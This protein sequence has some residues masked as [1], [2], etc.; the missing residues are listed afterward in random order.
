MGFTAEV[1][2]KFLALGCRETWRDLWHWIDITIVLFWL[3]GNLHELKLPLNPLLL[4]LVRLVRLLRLLKLIR[5]MQAMDAL[6]VILTSIKCSISILVWAIVV[7]TIG[8]M[9]FGLIAQQLLMPYMEDEAEL[10]EKRLNV[11]LHFGTFTRCW[12]T[13]LELTFGGWARIGRMLMEDVSGW[14]ALPILAHQ[15]MIGF[16]VLTVVRGVFM[17][18]TFKV[19]ETD[20]FIMMKTRKREANVHK[21]KMRRLFETADTDHDGFLDFDEFKTIMSNNWVKEWLFAYGLMV[22][23]VGKMWTLIDRNRD[24]KI[25][26]DE[27]VSGMR[28]LRG[29]ARSIDM[30]GLIHDIKGLGGDANSQVEVDSPATPFQNI[31]IFGPPE[32]E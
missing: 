16:A 20:N 21:T 27:L 13:M 11:F 18:Q 10:Y 5:K 24:S 26:A 3:A 31:R 29:P 25:S 12:F 9:M 1:I 2:L 14:W 23:D 7:L 28:V 22:D 15:F 17:Q 32:H 19:A 6:L 4:R 30:Q 8:E